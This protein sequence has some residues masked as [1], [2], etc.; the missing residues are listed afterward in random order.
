MKIMVYNTQHCALHPSKKIDFERI[1]EVIKDSGAEFVG[2]NEIRGKGITPEYEE[3]TEILSRLTGMKHSYFARAIFVGGT[4]PYGNALL[5]RYPIVSAEVIP[6]PDPPVKQNG[7]YYESRCLLKAKLECGL[8]VMVIHFGLN[9]DEQE[10]AVRTVLENLEEERC[11]LMGD[12]NVTPDD[13]VLAPIRER[14][15]DTAELFTE[16]KLSYPSDGPKIK[17][18]YIFTSR[19]VKVMAADI[20]AVVAS[21]HRPYTAE[22]EF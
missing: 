15:R 9:P 5:S 20:P 6:V 22:I 14:M 12:F 11:V 10:N 2:L 16:E 4:E 21:D 7:K 13:P 18:D 3:Q 1:A 17:I 19:D 8:T